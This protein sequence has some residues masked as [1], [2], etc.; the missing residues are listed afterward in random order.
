MKKRFAWLLAFAMCAAVMTADE[1]KDN[2]K[3]EDRIKSS[4]TVLDEI[5]SAPD[6]GIPESILKSAECVA[7]VPSMLKGGFVVAASYGRGVASCRTAKG[8]SA[9]AF[10]F[11]SGGSFGFQI[12]GQATDLV[13][14]IMN[15]DGMT[16]L[17]SSKFK[18]GADASVAAGPV[19]RAAA[20]DT[21]WKL[22]AQVLTYSR[23]RGVFAGVSL[24]GA[25]IKQ[26]KD[27]TREFY[28]RMVPFK[29]SLTG[30]IEAPQGAYPFLSVLA[31]W[32]K[33]AADK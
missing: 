14:L 24:A 9:P 30:E 5:E 8:W 1:V 31:K 21:D 20:A 10:L 19:G 26:D 2:T 12:G 17:L 33:A 7:V 11:T 32:A 28:N 4:G 6:S 3:A 22:R 25:V 15:K 16:N 23:S 29:T 27:A 18:L 13:L